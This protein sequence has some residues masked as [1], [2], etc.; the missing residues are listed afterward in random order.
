MEQ[1]LADQS[2]ALFRLLG[3]P[4]RVRILQTLAETDEVCVHQIATA[5][6]TSE[7]K[8][9]QAL[10]LLRTAR[11]VKNR[12]AGRHIHYR[13]DDDHVSTLLAVTFEH[14]SH[15]AVHQARRT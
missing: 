13:L 1:D 8:V 10:R 11:V 7:T 3:D 14:L 6:G 12:R 5:V 2:A 4:T 9:S 15:Q